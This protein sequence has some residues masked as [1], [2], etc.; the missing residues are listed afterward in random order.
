M[1]QTGTPT[2][3]IASNRL[4]GEFLIRVLASDHF[5][6]PILCDKLPHPRLRS[7]PA[8]FIIERSHLPLP[9]RDC[10]RRLRFLFPKGRFVMVYE[11]LPEEEIVMLMRLGIQGFVEHSEV[12]DCLA[13]A[14]RIIAAGRLW[15]PE[16]LADKYIASTVQPFDQKCRLPTPR[17]T[18]VLELVRRRLSN[19]EIARALKIS[20]ST[21][22]YHLSHI[23][24]KYG[25]GSRRGLESAS[26]ASE[27]PIWGELSKADL[28]G[29]PQ[30]QGPTQATN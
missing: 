3:I 7:I 28:S 17:E 13:K 29:R 16:G 22:K 18:E 1:V 25:T 14:L 12:V 4:A 30:S 26:K 20:V 9:L 23:L 5:V 11:T 15:M 21:V 10:I 27:S 2:Y 6:R 8:I 24:S 19:R